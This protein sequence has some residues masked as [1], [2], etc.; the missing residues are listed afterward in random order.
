MIAFCRH[1]QSGLYDIDL[2]NNLNANF[3][4][5]NFVKQSFRL[6]EMY[7]KPW[8]NNKMPPWQPLA[9]TKEMSI[10]QDLFQTDSLQ[11]SSMSLAKPQYRP[12][13]QGNDVEPF[14]Y[15]LLCY[16]LKCYDIIVVAYI[17]SWY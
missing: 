9:Y 17:A 7:I 8:E 11:A 13:A 5:G 2:W 16:M 14:S 10:S 3:G 15:L 12:P 4:F 6:F 1:E